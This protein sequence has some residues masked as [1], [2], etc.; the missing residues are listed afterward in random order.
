MIGENK[1]LNAK[2]RYDKAMIDAGYVRVQGWVKPE[3]KPKVELL[4]KTKA[5]LDASKGE[6]LVKKGEK[7][8]LKNV[9]SNK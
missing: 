3:D 2:Q 1:E 6:H 4:L 9:A 7:K 5:G 8:A